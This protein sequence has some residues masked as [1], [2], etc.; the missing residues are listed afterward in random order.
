MHV[1]LA[2]VTRSGFAESVHFGSVVGLDPA[3]RVALALGAVEEPI[4]P[5]SGL[6]PLQALGCLAAGA[7][8]AGEQLA[9]AAGSHLGEDRHVATVEAMLAGAGL[10]ADALGCPADWP[11]GEEVKEAL[12]GTGGTRSRLRH[13]CSGKHAAMLAASV[14]NGWPTDG[15]LE[16]EHPV[17]RRIRATVEEL[18]GETAAHVAVDGCGA[19]VLALTLSGLARAIRS[20]QDVARAMRAHPEYVA[21]DGHVN[22]ELMRA[23]PG[24][25]AKGGA[26]GVLVAATAEGHAVAVKVIDG[27]QRAT[28]PIALAALE[29]VGV[30]VG[31]AEHLRTVPVLG[32]GRPVGEVRARAVIAGEAAPRHRG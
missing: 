3:G 6:K 10:T 1:P 14:A 19:P 7:D 30:D 20:L 8:L 26:E 32:G 24:A 17:Q 13:N 4:L 31:P 5:R 22:T 25:I 28:T 2:E 23:L 27:A 18:A 15:Y 11:L 29:A 16:P 12:I 21:G 9:I